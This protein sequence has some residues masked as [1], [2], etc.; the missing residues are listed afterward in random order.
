MAQFHIDSEGPGDEGGL[1][2][3]NALTGSDITSKLALSEPQV[4]WAEVSSGKTG[5]SQVLSD[6]KSLVNSAMTGWSNSM[7]GGMGR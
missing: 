3:V 5:R 2:G 4:S 6:A 7:V 1:A